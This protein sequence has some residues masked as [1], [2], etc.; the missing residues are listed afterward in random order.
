[1]QKLLVKC[2]D[3]QKL[4]NTIIASFKNAAVKDLEISRNFLQQHT[5]QKAANFFN[6][7]GKKLIT[8]Q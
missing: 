4:K 2:L 3:M 6:R 8:F 1:M 7:I 5:I